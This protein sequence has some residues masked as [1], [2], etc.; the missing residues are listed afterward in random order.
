MVF[1]GVDVKWRAGNH[2][3]NGLPCSLTSPVCSII[4]EASYNFMV[5]VILF[6][7]KFFNADVKPPPIPWGL[8]YIGSSLT[9]QGYT[10]ELID[11]LIMPDWQDRMEQK[12]KQKPLCVGIS[13]MTGNQIKHGLNFSGFIKTHS[14]IPVVWGGIH[15][16]LFPE[17]TLSHPHV[18]YVVKGEGE[19]TIVKLMN[20]LKNRENPETVLGLGYKKNS[21]IVLNPDRPFPVL[22][23]L[24][25]IDY[26]LIEVN[27]Y[28]GN[29]FGS[30]KSF[31]LCT[32][33]GCPHRC[34]FC[35]NINHFKCTWRTMGIDRIFSDLHTLVDQHDIDAITWRED[36]FF[37]DRKRTKE[38]AERIIEEN[39]QIKWHADCRIDYLHN[40]D[41]TFMTLLKKSG[42]HTLTFGAESGSD[43]IL[44]SIQKGITREQIIDVQEK[45]SRHQIYQ[46]YHFIMGLPNENPEDLKQTIDLIYQ[47]I[48]KNPYFG[49]ICGPS[50]YTPYPGTPLYDECLKLGFTPPDSLEGW[51]KMDW[52]SLNLPWLTEKK[53]QMVE[54]IAWN[55]MGMKHKK[56]R[57]YFKWKL[58]LLSK[59]HIHIPCF[60]KKLYFWIKKRQVKIPGEP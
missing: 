3:R 39:L 37:V 45:M 12:L 17:Q 36:N 7:P 30:Q 23:D 35:Y 27:R 46:N 54:D 21:E 18:D 58:L 29:R 9:R 41:D 38:I 4:N 24:P 57:Q 51:I 10:V 11:E 14:K 49:E 52:Y 25:P 55:I 56:A 1:L 48:D 20:V 34:A 50:L 16:S 6:R 13:S 22:D 59:Y 31:E 26:S 28:T 15:P 5:D 44:K 33:R 53:R 19:E 60:E 47:L 40:C 42:C 32:S 2:A 8:L 43:N